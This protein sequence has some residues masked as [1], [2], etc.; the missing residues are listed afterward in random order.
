MGLIYLPSTAFSPAWLNAFLDSCSK[1][2]TSFTITESSGFSIVQKEKQNK[3]HENFSFSIS[4]ATELNLFLHCVKSGNSC[5]LLSF[6]IPSAVH[7]PL[8]SC[9][10]LFKLT[11]PRLFKFY[12]DARFFTQTW[13]L[14]TNT[15]FKQKFETETVNDIQDVDITHLWPRTENCSSSIFTLHLST[16]N[17]IS[18]FYIPVIQ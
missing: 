9:S 6:L 1:L 10:I 15:F 16:E 12:S 7:K 4:A 14:F 13:W 17:Y 18:S 11:R 3:T 8:C 5:S 2:T